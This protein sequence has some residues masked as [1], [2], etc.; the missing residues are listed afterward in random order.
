MFLVKK[1]APSAV[2]RMIYYIPSFGQEVRK[3]FGK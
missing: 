3:R 1:I 2:A